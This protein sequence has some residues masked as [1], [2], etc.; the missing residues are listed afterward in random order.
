MQWHLMAKMRALYTLLIFTCACEAMAQSVTYNHDSAKQN[1]FTVAEI[2]S[3]GLT[4]SLYYTLLHGSYR[5]SAAAKNKLAFRTTSSVAAYWQVDD[6]A[7]I[8]SAMTKRAEVEALNVADRSGGALDV[9]WMAEGGKINGKMADFKR[10][11]DR[12]LQFGG[13]PDQ[14][15]QWTEL[16]NVY[17]T[18]VKATQEAYMPNSE[19]KKQYLQIY[20]DVCRKNETLVRYLVHLS[21]SKATARLLTATYEKPSPVQRV[22][23]SAFSRWRD[24]GWNVT[25]KTSN[26]GV[27]PDRWNRTPIDGEQVIEW[28][29]TPT[30]S[31]N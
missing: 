23:A 30:V 9:A 28:E 21:N 13:V 4:P 14:Q 1:Q 2:G 26:G 19:R 27:T 3:G 22:A 8:D 18:A 31:K 15:K 10:N 29:G 7:D 24:A 16:Y 12:I 17:Q 25:T 5:K 20:A 11:I 6:A